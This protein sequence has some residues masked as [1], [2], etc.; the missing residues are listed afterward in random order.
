M[1]RLKSS[2]E[3]LTV[4]SMLLFLNSCQKDS[5][6]FSQT[7]YKFTRVGSSGEKVI[8]E[9]NNEGYIIKA[10]YGAESGQKVTTR[11]EYDR[12]SGIVNKALSKDQNGNFFTSQIYSNSYDEA[13]NLIRSRFS[14]AKPSSD[15]D[16]NY[17]NYYLYEYEDGKLSSFKCSPD[18]NPCHS[19]FSFYYYYNEK[20]ELFMELDS[21][22][23]SDHEY[24]RTTLHYEYFNDSKLR[25]VTF[26]SNNDSLIKSRFQFTY[27]DSRLK[28]VKYYYSEQN[29]FCLDH[30]DSMIYDEYGR[31]LRQYTYENSSTSLIAEYNYPSVFNI[32]P[33]LEPD[34]T[35]EMLMLRI[36]KYG[37]V[38][39]ISPVWDQ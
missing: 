14:Y 9:V 13:G 16:E 8:Y 17:Y 2:L 3:C 36:P 32:R 19:Y 11:F 25:T 10:V 26:Y 20:G 39:S 15:L 34:R 38:N 31:F 33:I 7:V 28:T 1:R 6:D 29:N 21:N 22:R 4:I 18:T 27:I 35:Y 24:F 23:Y 37:L 5:D 12:N 30:I